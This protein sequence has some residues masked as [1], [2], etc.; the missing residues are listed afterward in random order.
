MRKAIV[1]LLF[2]ACA[3]FAGAQVPVSGSNVQDS[4]G[5]PLASGQWCFA[6]TCLTVTN[7]AFSDL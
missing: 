1:Y 5:V 4:T 7:G 6:S 2:L 3:V